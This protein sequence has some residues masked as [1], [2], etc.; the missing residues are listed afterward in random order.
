MSLSGNLVML[1][2]PE[3]NIEQLCIC[4]SKWGARLKWMRDFCSVLV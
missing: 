2:P 4:L 1:L 3:I